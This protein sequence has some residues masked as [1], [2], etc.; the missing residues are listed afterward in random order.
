[1]PLDHLLLDETKALPAIV[2]VRL[3]NQA[4]HFVV[5]WRRHGPWLQVMDPAVGRRWVRASEFLRDVH[6]H[7]QAVPAEGWREW[8]GGDQFVPGLMR[9]M[10]KLGISERD[11]I[12][13]E[14]LSDPGWKRIGS[15]DA[16]TRMVAALVE[17]GALGRGRSAG[18][19]VRNLAS[20]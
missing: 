7:T 18:A 11:A 10:A 16:A 15:L 6:L 14:A 12:V 2:V 13:T 9:R 19:L 8:A 1:V 4:T 5:V 20:E 3:A 17:T